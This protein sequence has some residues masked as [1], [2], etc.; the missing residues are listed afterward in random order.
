V[1]TGVSE[2]L[3]K[4]LPKPNMYFTVGLPG[5]GDHWLRKRFIAAIEERKQDQAE[6]FGWTIPDLG[7]EEW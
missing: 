2:D 7:G 3:N 6:D 5:A 4:P 1:G